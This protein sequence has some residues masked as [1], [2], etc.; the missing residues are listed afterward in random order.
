MT[1]DPLRPVIK[2]IRN[3]FKKPPA[4]I[5]RLFLCPYKDC[6][7][8]FHR[9]TQFTRHA[10][11]NHL[12]NNCG[13]F[14]AK[15]RT[16]DGCAENRLG[17]GLASHGQLPTELNLGDFV[18]ESTVYRGTLLTFR[19]TFKKAL[20][21]FSEVY[22]DS[23][24]DLENILGYFVQL[25]KG[26]RASVSIHATLEDMKG[27]NT[28]DHYFFSP[29]LRFTHA[30]LITQTVMASADYLI[31]SLNLFAE[32]GSGYKLHSVN[33]ME[34]RLG[35]YKPMRIKGY[36]ATPNAIG[37]KNVIN[38]KTKDDSCFM[39]SVLAGLKLGELRLPKTP[40]LRYAD[41]LKNEKKRFKTMYENPVSYRKL[42][43]KVTLSGEIDFS[44]FTGAE[45]PDQIDEF[46]KKNPHI[47]IS[48]FDHD[49]RT[50]KNCKTR[51][52][53]P[54]QLA[55]FETNP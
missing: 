34:V 17:F 30:S 21:S 28:R 44:G 51:K 38:I 54:R 49:Q 23:F 9:T 13:E 42:L 11:I 14:F 43:A 50:I 3:P 24:T 19:K 18:V 8:I 36:I 41:A 7:A 22:E 16:H 55:S 20:G 53:K 33:Y 4:N 1:I 25:Y 10:F 39:L 15:L 6:E 45:E 46:E 26:I 29:F 12:C 31:T 27:E 2:I 5:T 40:H 47:S 52:R 35:K 37:R 48:V 32:D